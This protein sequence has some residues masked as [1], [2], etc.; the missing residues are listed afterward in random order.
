MSRASEIEKTEIIRIHLEQEL[1][2]V[3][4]KIKKIQIGDK[5][6]F[7]FGWRKA[8]KGRT[9]WRI[10]EEVINQQLEVK[11]KGIIKF[12][13]SDSEISVYDFKATLQ[14]G[15]HCFVNIKSSSLNAKPSKDDLSKADKLLLFLKENPGRELFVA[16]FAI[17]FCDDMSI[18][19]PHCH[20]FPIAW[21]PDIYVNPSNNGNLQ[22]A[23]YKD[24]GKAVKRTNTEFIN[25]LEKAILT[26]NQKKRQKK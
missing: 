9:V 21:I 8:A 7:P 20:I 17:E 19:L 26:A 25:E 3:L 18:R 23:Y 24:L 12:E 10:L 2:E 4:T 15:N 22:S 13:P 6:A 14:D 1:T 5:V 11:S 16:T